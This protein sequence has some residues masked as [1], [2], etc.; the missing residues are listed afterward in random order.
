MMLEIMLALIAGLSVGTF[1]GLVP[2]IH[3]N[4]AVAFIISLP[5]LAA[6][7]PLEVSVF[8][9]SAAVTH[10]FTDFIA[11]IY[12]GCP[13]LRPRFRYCRGTGCF[14]RAEARMP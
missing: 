10:T 13:I 4:T 3:T 1:T 9:I 7:S 14:W 5:F 2:G 6:F 12:I 11:S 8:I